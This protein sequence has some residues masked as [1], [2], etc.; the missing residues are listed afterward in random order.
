ME[1]WGDGE[2]E[3]WGKKGSL[4]TARTTTTKSTS[5][6]SACRIVPSASSAVA[7]SD[8]QIVPSF[9]GQQLSKQIKINAMVAADPGGTGRL[10]KR[11][12][13]SAGSAAIVKR[14]LNHAMS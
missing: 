4:A 11:P 1:P 9:S 6:C 10:G 2:M 8:F 12:T 7:F 13:T 3:L 14:E 5:A